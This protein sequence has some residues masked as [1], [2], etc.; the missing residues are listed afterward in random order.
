LKLEKVFLLDYGIEFIS[1]NEFILNSDGQ[2]NINYFV[3]NII[4]KF[5]NVDETIYIYSDSVK[6]KIIV[7]T[8]IPELKGIVEEYKM[9]ELKKGLFL[10]TEKSNYKFNDVIFDSHGDHLRYYERNPVAFLE[11]QKTDEIYGYRGAENIGAFLSIMYSI[12]FYHILFESISSISGNLEFS[13]WYLTDLFDNIENDLCYL[14]RNFFSQRKK[15]NEKIK[16]AWN[17]VNY[18]LSFSNEKAYHRISETYGGYFPSIVYDS[19]NA[20]KYAE[21]NEYKFAYTP[22][23]KEVGNNLVNLSDVLRHFYDEL[24]SNKNEWFKTHSDNLI[25]NKFIIT[26]A[27][28]FIALILTLISTLNGG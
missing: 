26:T 9:K 8:N 27:L 25:N 14:Q 1:D 22:I 2:T 5:H 19:I 18:L 15:I 13:S 4:K 12:G 21:I 20:I 10:G 6:L 28:S 17:K 24:I 3:D 16:N 23:K 7:C 11:P